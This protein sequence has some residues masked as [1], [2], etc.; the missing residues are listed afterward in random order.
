MSTI[1]GICTHE[2]SDKCCYLEIEWKGNSYRNRITDRKYHVESTTRG[3]LQA[4]ERL[5]QNTVL[6][7]FHVNKEKFRKPKG[8]VLWRPQVLHSMTYPICQKVIAFETSRASYHCIVLMIT[9]LKFV[10]LLCLHGI[11]LWKKFTCKIMSKFCPVN[12]FS[13]QKFWLAFKFT[14]FNSFWSSCQSWQ[15]R[16]RKRFSLLSALRGWMHVSETMIKFHL[17]AQDFCCL[18]RI[19]NGFIN[20]FA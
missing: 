18:S 14:R 17:S 16:Y 2:F 4:Y 6:R 5:R 10:P 8:K 15:I 12:S 7:I 20:C 13:Y 19:E 3:D 9:K 1:N 11:L